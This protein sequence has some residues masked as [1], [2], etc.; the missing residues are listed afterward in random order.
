MTLV[1]ESLILDRNPSQVGFIDD[2]V[3]SPASSIVGAIYVDASRRSIADLAL[4]HRPGVTLKT[5]RLD[6]PDYKRYLD[7]TISVLEHNTHPSKVVERTLAWLIVEAEAGIADGFKKYPSN[8]NRLKV[9]WREDRPLIEIA[10]DLQTLVN[11]VLTLVKPYPVRDG[12]SPQ[13]RLLDALDISIQGWHRDSSSHHVGSRQ[14]AFFHE[15][16][17]VNPL[18]TLFAETLVC[19][20]SEKMPFE[21]V[22]SLHQV[23]E[24]TIEGRAVLVHEPIVDTILSVLDEAPEPNYNEWENP[25][26]LSET[27]Q[28]RRQNTLIN[29]GLAEE[30]NP[31][32]A[33][34]IQCRYLGENAPSMEAIVDLSFDLPLL[35]RAFQK[36]GVPGSEQLAGWHKENALSKWIEY[37][38]GCSPEVAQGFLNGELHR[39]ICSPDQGDKTTLR[40]EQ[41][42]NMKDVFGILGQDIDTS[43]FLTLAV[44]DL[45]EPLL[46]YVSKNGIEGL[47]MTI[48]SA[49][50]ESWFVAAE[51]LFGFDGQGLR[52]AFK[53]IK[54]NREFLG[55]GFF[56]RDEGGVEWHANNSSLSMPLAVQILTNPERPL[57]KEDIED[58]KRAQPLIERL[59]GHAFKS[60]LEEGVALTISQWGDLAAAVHGLGACSD[61]RRVHRFRVE[62]GFIGQEE[63]EED[64]K[65]FDLKT[66]AGKKR[67]ISWAK[68]HL[69]AEGR[70][71]SSL[72]KQVAQSAE[73]VQG[74]LKLR[75]FLPELAE[76]GE[77]NSIK[78]LEAL[79]LATKGKGERLVEMLTDSALQREISPLTE[80]LFSILDHRAKSL[81]LGLMKPELGASPSLEN[82]S[83]SQLTS[84]TSR[85]LNLMGFDELSRELIVTSPAISRVG[86]RAHNMALYFAKEHADRLLS[87]L[88]SEYDSTAR[89]VEVNAK[90]GFS[91]EQYK[92]Q[93]TKE[94]L[95]QVSQLLKDERALKTL[96]KVVLDKSVTRAS[97]SESEISLSELE[98]KQ[99]VFHEVGHHVENSVPGLYEVCQSFRGKRADSTTP[100]RLKQLVPNSTY[101]DDEQAYPGN[102]ISPYVGKIYAGQR[103]TEVFSMGLQHFA[104]AEDL[105]SLIVKDH[106]HF[107]LT[108]GTILRCRGEL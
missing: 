14:I 55:G 72:L 75:A 49:P 21:H 106:E 93:R 66:E 43:D 42:S 70:T 74:V 62:V 36:H 83:V 92:I 15:D 16:R 7:A 67:F 24:Q 31:L 23:L 6:A 65:V 34:A 19:A 27:L 100:V 81:L 78:I 89:T 40:L 53:G 57:K 77:A 84:T 76:I 29:D 18:L 91:G 80:V 86:T 61:E 71:Q 28:W 20:A 35:L 58:E 44:E 37:H 54:G 4:H 88:A 32:E 48:P 1:E 47:R 50:N 51:T 69:G 103:A 63:G 3:N 46:N 60:L 39:A 73:A 94:E 17:R 95:R 5:G 30:L 85:W 9:D 52:D 79:H 56:S 99:T 33:I 96:K 11:P 10:R 45:S 105:A 8:V 64:S 25:E 68:Q 97:A 98:D 41:S 90:T 82:V 2:L 59:G 87:R 26:K 12:E 13:L 101:R 104:S 22:I 102:F 107:L 38:T 108:L